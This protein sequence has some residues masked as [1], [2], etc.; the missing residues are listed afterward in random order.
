MESANNIGFREYLL[1]PEPNIGKRAEIVAKHLLTEVIHWSIGIKKDDA[2]ITYYPSEFDGDENSSPFVVRLFDWVV[3]GLWELKFGNMDSNEPGE[4]FKWNKDDPNRVKKA[5]FLIDVLEN[6]VPK[7]FEDGTIEKLVF[8]PYNSDGL[9][10]DRL[11]Y[12]KNMFN[13]INKNNEYDW[14]FDENAYIISKKESVQEIKTIKKSE[15]RSLIKEELKSMAP[16]KTTIKDRFLYESKKT[17]NEIK[18]S[19]ENAYSLEG[20]EYE[21]KFEA[22]S[23]TYEYFVEKLDSPLYLPENMKIEGDIYNVF[24]KRKED[25]KLDYDSYKL[26][27]GK[28]NLVKIYSTIYKIYVN[29][30]NK[31]KPDYL[32]IHSLEPKYFS[33]Y[34]SIVKENPIPGYRIKTT[35]SYIDSYGDNNQ[36]IVLQKV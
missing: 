11:S 26:V 30:I 25:D 16:I 31:F 7:L 17:I 35:T 19:V 3:D 13:K 12:F 4:K 24:F 14:R 1:H 8:T 20:N 10:N 33:V 2:G 9:G 36:S 27:S 23:Q 22:P 6:E 29:T 15:L 18:L 32:M 5:L 21:G 28:A 34:K